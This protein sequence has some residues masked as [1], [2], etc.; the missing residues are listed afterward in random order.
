MMQLTRWIGWSVAPLVWVAA[1]V[2]H[3][4]A[5]VRPGRLPSWESAAVFA[6]AGLAVWIGSGLVLH[7]AGRRTG[8][9]TV[10][11]GTFFAAWGL[12]QLPL[13]VEA[14]GAFLMLDP[15]WPQV[16]GYAL[17]VTALMLVLPAGLIIFLTRTAGMARPWAFAFGLVGWYLWLTKVWVP[18]QR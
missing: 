2:A 9:G 16:F 18:I 10:D 1:G 12:T 6:V 7:A 8:R 5:N 14:I 15:G 11:L 13:G 3:K 17:T 4:V